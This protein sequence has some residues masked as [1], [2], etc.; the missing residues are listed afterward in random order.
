VDKVQSGVSREHEVDEGHYPF[1]EF[2]PKWRDRWEEVGLFQV[3]LDSSRKKYYCLNMFPYPSGDLHVGHGRN[4]ILGDVVVRRRTMEG[5]EVLAP[6]GWDA[7]GLPA[8]NAAIKEGIHPRDW[9]LVNIEKFKEQFREWGI[10]LDWTRE[11]AACH[12]GYYRWTQWLFLQLFHAGLAEKRLAPVNWCPSC[13]T[14][15]AN[16]QVVDGICER[17]D[18]PVEQRELSQWFF[19]TTAYAETLLEDLEELEHWPERVVTMQRNWI[20]RSEGVQI[21]FPRPG[22][23]EAVECFTTRIDT[24]GGVTYVVL[25]PEHPLVDELLAAHPRE[26]ELRARVQDMRNQRS[27]RQADPDLEKVGFDTGHRVLNPINGEEVPLWVANYVLM[28][29]GTGAVMA[30]PAHDQRDL[31][32][33]RKYGL[34]VRIVVR[35]VEEA[36][37]TAGEAEDLEEAWTGAGTLVQSG[38]FDGLD[39]E[40]AK[41]AI[42]TWLAEE[43]R[44]GFTVTY[45]LRDWLIS[46]QRY[47]GAPIPIIYCDS[48]GTVPVPEADLPV[49]LPMDVDFRPSGDSPLVRHPAFRETVCPRCGDPGRRETDTMDTFVDSSWYFLRFLSPRDTERPFASEAANRWMPVDQYI[50]GVEHAILH[51]LYARFITK[52]L[53]DQSWLEVREPFARLFTQGM[54]T[55]RSPLTGRLEKMSKSKGNVV[56]PRDLIRKYGVDTVRIYTL[57]LGPPDKD[58]E[59]ED[60]AVE[61]ASRFLSRVWRLCR[62]ARGHMAAPETKVDRESLGEPGLALHRKTHD[63]IARVNEDLDRF[64]MNTAIAALMELTNTLSITLQDSRFAPAPDRAEGAALRETVDRLLV[65][66]APMAPFLS[67]ELWEAT[68]HEGTIFGASIPRH[69]PAALVRESFTLVVQVRGKVR[70]RLEVPVT[71]SEEEVTALALADPNVKTHLG[72]QAPRKAIYVPGKLLNLVP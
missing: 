45:R 67:E 35:N 36:P 71:V 10:G 15:L 43:G 7:F 8:E 65:L 16:E 9:T 26:E 47:W 72:G 25:A 24:L 51:L 3:D 46:R 4:Y 12:P 39:N 68:G 29:Y 28:E 6:M 49:L 55:K 5:F 61:G 34:P 14:V 54:I 27:A 33:A 37:G 66:L 13:A 2:E 38:V 19:R 58:A 20:G 41:H 64:Q 42:G 18:T 40:T 21:A 62:Q 23:E 22:R 59:W 30:V 53:A 17:C 11:I 57:F 44:G 50:G 69:D 52:F 70:A 48:C 31:L 32:F 63:T 60:R 56:A 1:H